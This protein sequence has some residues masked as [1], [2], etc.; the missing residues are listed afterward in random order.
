MYNFVSIGARS[1]RL[2]PDAMNSR[3]PDP[4]VPEPL[5]DP[6]S[7]GAWLDLVHDQVASLKFGT[8]LITVHDRRVVQVEKNERFRL[9]SPLVD[10]AN[11]PT[12]LSGG[13]S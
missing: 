5:R 2:M 13:N 7:L 6:Q 3:H 9:N 8:V 12:R 1:K 10:H 11:Q 4:A